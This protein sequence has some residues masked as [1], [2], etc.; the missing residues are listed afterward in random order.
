MTDAIV[1]KDAARTENDVRW[2]AVEDWRSARRAAE[3]AKRQLNVATAAL[4]NAES[5]LIKVLIPPGAELGDKFCIWVGSLLVQ[6]TVS[7]KNPI[8]GEISIRSSEGRVDFE[9]ALIDY[10]PA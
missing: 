6:V 4:Y 7:G 1:E 10:K 5:R 3:E 2:R 8:A 9:G